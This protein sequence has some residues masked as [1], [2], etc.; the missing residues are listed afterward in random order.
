ML[1]GFVAILAASGSGCGG[2]GEA[3]SGT[4]E[5]DETAIQSATTTDSSEPTP[6]PAELVPQLSDVPSG[7][8]VDEEE[9]GPVPIGDLLEDRTAEEI[10]SIRR[11][12]VASYDIVF[13]SP[14]ATF[15]LCRAS[16]YRSSDGAEE[17]FRG[18]VDRALETAKE[19]GGEAQPARIAVTL[20]DETAAYTV[21]YEGESGFAVI[22]RDRNVFS[23][24][25]S[26][27]PLG[28]DSAETV[29][30]AQAQQRRIAESLG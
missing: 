6:D 11:E 21:G 7:Y 20:G 13:V 27:G 3:G 22:W 18:F 17:R 23:Q 9:T 8:L 5:P 4:A 30:V 24:C 29:R 1:F 2:G 26:G 19:E 28:A 12:F 15:I 16:V 14:D 10:E 25:G